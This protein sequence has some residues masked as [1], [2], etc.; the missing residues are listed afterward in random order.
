[1]LGQRSHTLLRH[2]WI[3]FVILAWSSGTT[4]GQEEPVVDTRNKPVPLAL[5]DTISVD[6]NDVLMRDAL[7]EVARKGQFTLNYNENILEKNAVVKYS[8]Q[9]QPAF[10]VLRTILRNTQI[11]IIVLNA[12]QVILTKRRSSPP[13]GSSG[14]HTLSGYVTDAATGEALVG[15][16]VY[17]GDIGA[18]MATN[19][20]GF[21][22]LT[23]PRGEYIV[24]YS[25]LGYASAASYIELDTDVKNDV[26]LQGRSIEVDT[27]L[28]LSEGFTASTSTTALGTV[29][30]NPEK[31]TA[32][33]VLFGEQDPLKVMQ[34]LPGVSNP[35]EGDCGI[36]VRGGNG[37][38]NLILLD[39][40]TMYSPFH[41]FGLFSV[42]N[43]DAIKNITLVKGSAPAKF[44][45]RLSS[46]IDMQMKEGNMKE[47]DGVA[48]I[49]L[50]F[51][52]M[53]LQGPIL[54]DKA[55]YLISGRRTYLDLLAK[56]FGAPGDLKFN[57]YDLNAKVNYKVDENDRLYLSGYFGRDGMGFSDEFD[58]TWGNTTGTIR[59]NHLF[60]DRLF[61]NSS[62]I[63]SDFTYR[64]DAGGEDTND[65]K[66]RWLSEVTTITLKEDFE[67]F[68]NGENILSFGANYVHHS[69][70]PADFSVTGDERFRF[71]IGEKS[72]HEV[73]AYI[74]HEHTIND[75]LRLE[76]GIRTGLFSVSGNAD[77][78]D[79]EEI[80]ELNVDFHEADTKTYFNLQPRVSAVYKLDES[81]SLKTGYSR[82]FQYLHMLS[83]SN[84]GTPLDVWQPSTSRIQPQIADQLSLGYF[85]NMQGDAY[86]FSAEVY[87]K[88]LQNQ[89]DY[90]EGAN[91]LLKSYFDSELVFGRGWAYGFELLLRKNSGVITGW[92]GYSLSASKRQFE[93]ISNGN[94]FPAKNDKPHEFMA[95]AQYKPGKKWQYSANF[96]YTSGYSTTL[97]F[98]RYMIAGREVMS[99]TDR[100]G[101]RLPSYHR[102]D[103]GISYFTDG[104]GIW[105]LSFYNIYGRRNIYTVI[106]RDKPNQPGLKEAVKISLFSVIPS[107][108]YTFTF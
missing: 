75:R 65:D 101:Y 106:V 61:L 39:E 30:L 17:L 107:L 56:T 89:I 62:F 93:E 67:Y 78:F 34:F 64:L 18:G 103:F 8:A 100:N 48:G 94:P 9:G 24:Q 80:D 4:Y 87:Y 25:Y 36:Y 14:K 10:L 41:T 49:G 79:I 3:L 28:I 42:F 7:H 45:G 35:R 108:S 50:I 47:F 66:V 77:H 37:D 27:V 88:Y 43:S 16:N 15:A 105:N 26:H 58:M 95:V 22:S 76:Y 6:F 29:H 85:R 69:F 60:N 21:Y 74:S 63:L 98:G 31:L 23:L 33:P 90:R 11:E 52:R 84:S 55:S 44:G 91:I 102:L 5:L 38:Q 40:A 1:M 70:L 32:V 96:V 54:R 13:G 51:S 68:Y 92:L 2:S 19:T 71:T 86:E 83:N 59:W 97:P 46:V 72:A 12:R 104:G 53:T 73:N 20:Y 81:S 82:N 57:F 99:Y